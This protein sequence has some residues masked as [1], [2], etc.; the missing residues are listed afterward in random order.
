[1]KSTVTLS[2]FVEAFRTMDRNENFSYDG[3]EALF[4]SFEE[5]MNENTMLVAKLANGNFV[6]AQF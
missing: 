6:Y 3:L 5:Y 4:N 2:T 1:M